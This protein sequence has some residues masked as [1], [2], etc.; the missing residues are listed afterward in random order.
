MLGRPI[1]GERLM[2]EKLNDSDRSEDYIYHYTSTSTA[3][4]FILPSRGIRFS[5]LQSTND[6]L[7][8]EN[9]THVVISN[10]EV[11]TE[12]TQLVLHE[13][14]K[15]VNII[16]RVCKVCCFSSDTEPNY[17]HFLNLMNKGFCLPRM[18]SQYGENHYGVCL[19]FDKNEL[20]KNI[21]DSKKFLI[22][23]NGEYQ[24]FNEYV[25][26]N[27]RLPGLDKALTMN[28]ENDKGKEAFILF[29]KNI[30]PFLF[31]KYENYKHE[32]EFRMVIHNSN[33]QNRKIID[34]DYGNSLKGIILGCR[35]KDVYLPSLNSVIVKY[36]I[37]IFQINWFNGRP[38]I[39]QK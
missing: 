19:V 21:C 22:S 30:T 39:Y 1:I 38:S 35:F 18:W 37:P 15:I 17:Q 9:F 26:Y 11:P 28:Y 3:I 7:E 23:E 33:F 12:E 27:D 13:G 16:K 29:K 24:F 20:I 5:S 4:E 10:A 6:P 36:N 2:L 31:T 14:T 32:Q 34:V 8:F 25:I